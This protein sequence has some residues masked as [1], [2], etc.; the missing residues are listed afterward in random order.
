M[1]SSHEYR[2]LYFTLLIIAILAGLLMLWHQ[3]G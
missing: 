3:F 2:R 1:L